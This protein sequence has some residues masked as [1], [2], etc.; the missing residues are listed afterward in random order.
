MAELK[1]SLEAQGFK[2]KELD[3]QTQL[4][5][6]N[7]SGQWNGTSEHNLMQDA[8]ERDRMTRLSQMRRE[9][10]SDSGAKLETVRQHT[11]ES[12]LHIVA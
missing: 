8:Q 9:A 7:L 11:P 12:G 1:A 4:Q 6:G 3:V 10:G 2:V 5:D